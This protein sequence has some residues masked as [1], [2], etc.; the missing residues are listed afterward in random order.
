MSWNTSVENSMNQS[1]FV[2]FRKKNYRRR[3]QILLWLSCSHAIIPS[4]CSI[5]LLHNI[6]EENSWAP[7]T[8]IAQVYQ[9]CWILTNTIEIYLSGGTSSGLANSPHLQH[10]MWQQLCWCVSK[11]GFDW[12]KRRAGY[13]EDVEEWCFLVF[14][15][16]FY[17]NYSTIKINVL[18]LE[19]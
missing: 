4:P 13:V 3:W 18:I 8:E 2:W 1:H 6:A 19:V 17:F 11:C 10:R 12:C 7:I 15:V 16:F 9:H 5:L 14:W